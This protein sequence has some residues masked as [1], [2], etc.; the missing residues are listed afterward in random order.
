VIEQFTRWPSALH[1]SRWHGIRRPLFWDSL[2]WIEDASIQQDEEHGG[3]RAQALWLEVFRYDVRPYYFKLFN[4]RLW[5]WRPK[6]RWDTGGISDVHD[7]ADGQI[8]PDGSIRISDEMLARL[9][10]HE[11]AMLEAM[12]ARAL[13]LAP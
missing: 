3:Y 5:R 2:F 4:A 6:D 8:E 10:M 1:Q 12:V 13:K 7:L 9:E 11:Y